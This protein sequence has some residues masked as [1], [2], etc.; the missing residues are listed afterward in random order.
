MRFL[1]RGGGGA[2]CDVGGGRSVRGCLTF[3]KLLKCLE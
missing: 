2:G 1:G 3:V